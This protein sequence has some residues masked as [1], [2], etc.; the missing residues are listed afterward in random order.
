M[1]N[2][3]SKARTNR[4]KVTNVERLMELVDMMPDVELD[5]DNEHGYS[6]STYNGT[7]YYGYPEDSGIEDEVD[8]PEEL[9]KILCP[10]T[11][12]MII[13]IGGEKLDICA[14]GCIITKDIIQT[15]NLAYLMAADIQNLSHMDINQDVWEMF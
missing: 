14:T 3:E 6:L 2:Y 8:I 13:E 15:Y 12:I 5:G 7:L 10:D 9:Q 11:Y 4:F 1:A